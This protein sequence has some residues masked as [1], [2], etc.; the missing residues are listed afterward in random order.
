MDNK[1]TK[2]GN[3]QKCPHCGAP[4][5]PMAVKCS[6]CGYEFRNVEALN[7]A[8]QL[9]EKLEAIDL[10]YRNK[11]AGNVFVGGNAMKILEEK[12][13]VVKNFPI[14]TTKEDLLD[15]SITMQSRWNNEE[16]DYL[17]KAFKVKY[18]E[19]VNKA[20]ILFPNDPAFQGILS[21]HEKDKK[22]ISPKTKALIGLVLFMLII[23]ILLIF[24][25]GQL[26]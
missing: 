23:I 3:V 15:F 18:D 17:R 26:G 1:S 25:I 4:V 10:A 19:C 9:A 14:P 13:T 6:T 21:Q 8:Q 16:V 24:G 12:T 22:K 2:Y 11:G 5:E 7:S 20:K